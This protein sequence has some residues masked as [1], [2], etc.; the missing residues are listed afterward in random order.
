LRL[1]NSLFFIIL[2]ILFLYKSF[3]CKDT[4]DDD[5]PQLHPQDA[6]LDLLMTSS[7]YEDYRD[8]KVLV[9]SNEDEPLLVGTLVGY[10]TITQAKNIVPL[11]RYDNKTFLCLGIVLPYDEKFESFLNTIS[12]NEQYR[13]C[14][15]MRNLTQHLYRIH[16]E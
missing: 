4:E 13:L 10:Q 3:V 14:V 11:V 12:P 1:Y 5:T 6:K 9:R 15:K 2:I 8:V 16:D 7:L